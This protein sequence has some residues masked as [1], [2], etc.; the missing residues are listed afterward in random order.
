MAKPK[1][2]YIPSTLNFDEWIKEKIFEPINEKEFLQ[3]AFFKIEVRQIRI[4]EEQYNKVFE[5]FKH[6]K[7]QPTTQNIITFLK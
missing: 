7:H 6:F 4:T 3:V 5:T 2:I 1:K